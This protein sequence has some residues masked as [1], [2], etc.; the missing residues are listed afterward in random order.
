MK[1]EEIGMKR[2]FVSGDLYLCAFL[3]VYLKQ[4]PSFKVEYGK[5][6]FIFPSDTSL[7]KAI[8]AYNAGSAANAFEYAQQIKR[9]RGEMLSRKG[10]EK[11]ERAKRDGKEKA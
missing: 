8:E 11:E 5:T 2:E 6:L 4:M 7:Y 9:L 1:L 10:I 3:S